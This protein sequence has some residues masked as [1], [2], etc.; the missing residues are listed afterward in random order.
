[1]TKNMINIR[2]RTMA[3]DMYYKSA[4]VL[5]YNIEYPWFCMNKCA[6][7]TGINQYYAAK[8]HSFLQYARKELYTTAVKQYEF[9]AANGYPLHTYEAMIRYDITYNQDC[10]V[11][12]YYDQ[13]EYTGGAHGNTVRS[14]DTWDVQNGSLIT[15]TDLFGCWVQDR[16]DIQN[17]ISRQIAQQIDK[18]FGNYFPDYQKNVSKYFNPHNFYLSC[19][20]IV[21]Y[22]QQ[23]QIAPYSSGIPEFTIP[24]DSAVLRPCY[25]KS[26]N[27]DT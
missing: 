4:L 14:S 11:S 24:C 1:M 22:F 15:L 10:I 9:D 6:S 5:T 18:G 25:S 20:G 3:A 7:V 2:P 23:Y 21:I 19:D 8:A 26:F 13:Y 16:R 12:L 17:E 27:T